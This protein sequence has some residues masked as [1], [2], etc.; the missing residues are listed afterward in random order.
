MKPFDC[1]KCSAKH[2]MVLHDTINN[3]DEPLDMCYNCIFSGIKYNTTPFQIT[4][5]EVVNFYREK[6][7]ETQSKLIENAENLEND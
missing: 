1:V 3:T 6:L 4:F 5:E 7:I 2:G